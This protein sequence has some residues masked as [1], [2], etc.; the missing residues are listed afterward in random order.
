MS[1]HTITSVLVYSAQ[2]ESVGGIESHVREFCLRLAGAGK[3]VTLLS[4]R[5]RMERDAR[6]Q[7][8]NAGVTLVLN[9]NRWFSASP[10]RKWLW[11]LAALARLSSRRFDVV[12]TNG[13]GR[14]PATVQ[15]WFRGRARLVH[16]HHMSSDATQ[17]ETWPDAYRASMRAADV[18]VVTAEFIRS[19]M[20]V[21][22]GRQDVRVAYCF[23]RKLPA[24]ARTLTP[25]SPVVFGYFGRLIDG[26][27]IDWIQRLSRD[28]RLRSVRWKVWGTEDRYRAADFHGFDNID[29]E[30]SFSDTE[31]LRAALDALDCFVLLSV[32]E[33]LP[34]SLMEVMGA[35][36]PWIATP[37]G[38][39]PELAHDPACCVLVGLEDYE[40]VV[41]ECLA[42]EAR[43]RSGQ[44]DSAAQQAFYESRLGER[45]LLTRWLALLEGRA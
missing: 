25:G 31:G 16:H 30:G 15:R 42:M 35:G 14:N 37:E 8:R 27:G 36:K 6:E 26:K 5:S 32:T 23:S 18:L 21:A 43:I 19:R 12:Y 10:S 3:R 28:P 33:G 4:S 38:G 45:A 7:L 1:R 13:Q 17:I 40:R 41:S 2:M 44:I 22:L 20:Q 11:T 24:P 39:I 29:Y 9:E 34:L